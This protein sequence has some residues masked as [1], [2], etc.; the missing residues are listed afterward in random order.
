M[1]IASIIGLVVVLVAGLS[2]CSIEKRHYRNGYY[3][4]GFHSRDQEVKEIANS[5]NVEFPEAVPT[6]VVEEN[7]TEP[8]RVSN[9]AEQNLATPTQDVVSTSAEKEIDPDPV[10][11]KHPSR[12]TPGIIEPDK[13]QAIGAGIAAALFFFLG[14]GGLVMTGA[15]GG[16]G[17]VG[18]FIGAAFVCFILCIV[19]ASFL[20][21]KEAKVKVPKEE[22]GTMPSG[23]KAVIG[24][25]L[26][27]LFLSALAVLGFA[28][29]FLSLILR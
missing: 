17:A 15:G 19:L 28:T 23:D 22:T 27:L 12:V 1:K 24:I 20:Y 7:A 3:L 14:M 11:V 2:S 5:E 29:W 4:S 26:T 16:G 25:G 18:I 21:P 6:V 9:V 10:A 8:I 13:N